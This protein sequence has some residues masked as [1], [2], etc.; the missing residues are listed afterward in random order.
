MSISSRF[1]MRTR[2]SMAT[3]VV[4]ES[5][6]FQVQRAMIDHC[7]DRRNSLCRARRCCAENPR[8]PDRRP[9]EGTRTCPRSG[10]VN[11]A[12]Y[13]PWIRTDRLRRHARAAERADLRESSA[14]TD[15]ESGVFTAPAN[16]EVQDATDL[17]A[18]LD[19]ALIALLNDRGIN[20][21]RAFPARGIRVWGARTLSRDAEWRYLNVRRLVLTSCDGLTPNM[22]WARSS[23]RP[24]AVGAHRT[25]ARHLSHG[26]GAP[27]RSGRRRPAMRSSCAATPSSTRR[28]PRGRASR[29]ADRLAPTEPA[30]FI[31]VTVQHRAGTTELT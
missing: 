15:A 9:A 30:E 16:I 21:I 2:C 7:A 3:G 17:D 4:D 27:G 12:L 14:R 1:R 31:V 8:R 24:R 22:T 19:P 29:D 28:R 6:V 20:C 23:Q 18:D 13:H 5:L 26:S 25:R 10:P 11:A